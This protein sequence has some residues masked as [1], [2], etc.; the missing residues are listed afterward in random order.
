MKFILLLIAT[1]L[2]IVEAG[3]AA[4]CRSEVAKYYRVFDSN[5]NGVV[6][7]GEARRAMVN[8][9]RHRFQVMAKSRCKGNAQ[10]VAIFKKHFRQF[11]QRF[12]PRFKKE[13]GQIC[14]GLRCT[15]KQFYRNG[16][17]AC[18]RG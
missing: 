4:R 17:K 16:F 8:N 6:T 2:V 14:P 1:L 10:C 13:F 9:V 7:W 3:K 15:K 18:M 5:R 11:K 12:V